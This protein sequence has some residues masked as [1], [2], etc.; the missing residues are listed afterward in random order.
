MLPFLLLVPLLF[1][2]GVVFAYFV[3]VPAATK[4]LLNF[5]QSEFNIQVRASEY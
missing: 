2:A 1:I 5:N 4:F 3:V